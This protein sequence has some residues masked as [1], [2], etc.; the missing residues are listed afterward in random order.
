MAI[1]VAL[2][3]DAMLGRGVGL[4]LA[5]VGPQG[6]FADGVR[7]AFAGSD[8]AVVNL[9]CCV[10]T[11]GRPWPGKR[12]HFRA[13][14]H[15]VDALA[16]LG[17]GCVSLANNHALD[18]GYDALADTRDHLADAGIEA[19]GAGGNVEQA[20]APVV[21]KVAGTRVALMAIT[22]HPT[23][24]A[25]GRDHPGVAYADLGS[26]VPDWVVRQIR[27]LRDQADVV[28]VMAHWGPNMTTEPPFYIR[29]VARA[30][31]KAGATLVAGSSAHLFHGVGSP[32]FYDLGDFIDDYA[33]H[34]SLRNDL[35]LMFLVTLDRSGPYRIEAVPLRL[36]YGYTRLAEGPD[37][38]WIKDRI[39]AACAEF[40]TH[41]TATDGR[42][43][44]DPDPYR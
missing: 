6:L 19:V 30:L 20:R 31:V 7:T 34:S 32:I 33:P 3:G 25:A 13:P 21:L 22:D 17:I 23:D 27:R 42:F 36:D 38:A 14:P 8:L 40:G 4:H 5:A 41:V 39:T 18:F 26:G 16:G 2:A 9:E 24:Y 37:R 28:V 12:F 29:R 11:R 43:Q 10:S 35:G 15:A 44:L 1:T